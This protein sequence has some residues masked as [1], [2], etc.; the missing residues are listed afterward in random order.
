M[1]H[2]KGSDLR[3]GNTY[4]AVSSLSNASI[5][6][7]Q[8]AGVDY[9]DWVRQTYLELPSDLSPQVAELAKQAT[10]GAHTPFDQA[11]AL[12]QVLRTFP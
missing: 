6:E 12:E 10:A 4:L 8:A 2:R 11:V 5:E 9:P 3:P 7:L 1:L